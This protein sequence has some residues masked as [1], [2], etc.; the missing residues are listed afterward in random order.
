MAH[1]QKVMFSF[2]AAQRMTQRLNVRVPTENDVD[3]SSAFF[4]AKTYI[5]HDGQMVEAWASRD[6]DNKIVLIVSRQSRVVLTVLLGGVLNDK[7]APF[8]D[9]CYADN[10]H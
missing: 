8:V 4:K 2:H 5:H 1:A 10:T 6:R 3:I 9:S 7:N